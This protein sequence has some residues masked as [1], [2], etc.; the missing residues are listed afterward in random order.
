VLAAW[1]LQRLSALLAAHSLAR[2]TPAAPVAT[3][4]E[5][6]MDATVGAVLVAKG[7]AVHET[8]RAPLWLL[9]SRAGSKWQPEGPIATGAGTWTRTIWLRGP[10]GTHHRLAVVAA[11]IPLHRQFEE[12]VAQAP[13]TPP[14]W[15]L[16]GQDACRGRGWRNADLGDGRTYPALPDGATLVTFGR[17]GRPPR[18]RPLN[19]DRRRSPSRSRG[20]PARMGC[21]R[22]PRR[23]SGWA[24]QPGRWTARCLRPSRSTDRPPAR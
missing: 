13:W 5:P 2:M 21:G 4:D 16:E 8:I 12:Q 9:S 7:R 20:R 1:P 24:G 6:A 3:I 19:V 18:R 14:C 10:A 23:R 17:G 15:W 22:E 11:E